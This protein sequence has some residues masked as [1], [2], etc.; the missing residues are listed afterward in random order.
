MAL[1]E[2]LLTGIVTRGANGER[3]VR[4]L[5]AAAVKS[6]DGKTVQQH[7][8]DVSIHVPVATL[9]STMDSKVTTAVNTLKDGADGSWPYLV[10][11]QAQHSA[12]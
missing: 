3:V 11:Y 10:V 7:V 2:K 8:D 9:E 6:T 1:I 5:A 12:F 4:P